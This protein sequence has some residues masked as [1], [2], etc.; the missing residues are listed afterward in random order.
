MEVKAYAKHIKMSPRKVRLVIDT[1]RGKK[2]ATALD[3]LRFNEKWAAEPVIK[4]VKSAVAN[5]MN[6]FDLD[7]NNLFI[8]EIKADEGSKLKRWMPKAHGRATQV[9][10]KMS[11]ITVTLGEIKDSGIKKGKNK[12]IEAPIKLGS[13]EDKSTGKKSHDDHDDIKS[14]GKN[15]EAG[16]KGFVGKMFNR[17]SG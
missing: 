8:K 11:H 14:T 6:N 5:A 9:L 17:K 2:I 16:S 13:V 1:V 12:D 15:V 7:I 3:I 10:K 4:V